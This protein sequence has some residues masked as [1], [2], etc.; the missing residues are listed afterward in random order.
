M[1]PTKETIQ[2]KENIIVSKTSKRKDAKH[3]H[4]IHLKPVQSPGKGKFS[5]RLKCSLTAEQQGNSV[6]TTQKISTKIQRQ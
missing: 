5:I 6:H 1:P 2:F 3:L 4:L